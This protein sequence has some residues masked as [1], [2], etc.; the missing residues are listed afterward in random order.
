MSWSI[1]IEFV[2][3]LRVSRCGER[4]QVISRLL[5]SVYEW[6]QYPSKAGGDHNGHLWFHE[7]SASHFGRVGQIHSYILWSTPRWPGEQKIL[8]IVTTLHK[9]KNKDGI[10]SYFFVIVGSLT[11][12]SCGGALAIGCHPEIN[13]FEGSPPPREWLCPTSTISRSVFLCLWN[14]AFLLEGLIYGRD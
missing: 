7:A 14:D 11:T 6:L 12:S 9:W 8:G 10:I 4:S 13:P 2:H 1:E 5:L 3:I